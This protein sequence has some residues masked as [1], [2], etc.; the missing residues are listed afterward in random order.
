MSELKLRE[1]VIKSFN[2][3]EDVSMLMNNNGY[4]TTIPSLVELKEIAKRANAH[5]NL[6]EQIA[7]LEAEKAEL[8]ECCKKDGGLFKLFDHNGKYQSAYK[9]DVLVKK[10]NRQGRYTIT[11]IKESDCE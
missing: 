1:V 11:V 8:I 5:D 2:N 3:G 6:V 4:T 10:T 9:G 7:K